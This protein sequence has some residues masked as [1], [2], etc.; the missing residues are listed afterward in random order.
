MIECVRCAFRAA[1]STWYAGPRIV[2]YSPFCQVQAAIAPRQLSEASARR[3]AECNLGG[4]DPAAQ[5]P[6]WWT[7]AQDERRS[8]NW[9]S[10]D[11]SR[12]AVREE[13]A[14]R[15]EA[16]LLGPASSGGQEEAVFGPRWACDRV[17]PPI[18]SSAAANSKEPRCFACSGRRIGA[19]LVECRFGAAF[20][21]KSACQ[22]G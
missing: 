6:E 1:S 21:G 17:G 19:Q 3:V 11:L 4:T 9:L 14:S 13:L 5:S 12:S 16:A 7:L 2:R 22:C 15:H 8:K 18:A 10:S 20:V